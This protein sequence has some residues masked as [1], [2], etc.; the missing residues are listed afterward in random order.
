[1]HSLCSLTTKICR[2]LEHPVKFH[3]LITE[4]A[5]GHRGQYICNMIWDNFIALHVGSNI[6][7]F[8]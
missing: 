8:M 1:M 2:I 4:N 3:S 6:F 7:K 5:E